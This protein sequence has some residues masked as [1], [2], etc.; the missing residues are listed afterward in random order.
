M[1]NKFSIPL[2]NFVLGKRVDRIPLGEYE[3]I[4]HDPYPIAPKKINGIHYSFNSS[5]FS[6]RG[7]RTESRYRHELL[8]LMTILKL[9]KEGTPFSNIVFYTRNKFDFMPHFQKW[10]SGKKYPF[11]KKYSIN[12][13]EVAK[14]VAFW[15]R[16]FRIPIGHFSVYHFVTADHNPYDDA[17]L[18]QYI[19]ALEHLLVIDGID[20][21]VTY[22]FLSRGTIILGENLDSSGKRKLYNDLKQFYD[23]RSS[24]VHGG[25][26]PDK[27]KLLKNLPLARAQCRAA[28]KYFFEHDTLTDRDKRSKFINDVVLFP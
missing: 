24:I 26:Q 10:R 11:S 8:K 22:K 19:S 12:V 17:M 7:P 9:F 20:G 4:R 23:Y 6:F 18:L 21:N 28:I 5:S 2:Y 16:Y 13:G 27:D 15:D 1:A 3:I 14:F 25:K